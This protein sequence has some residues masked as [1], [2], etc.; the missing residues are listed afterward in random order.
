[1]QTSSDKVHKENKIQQRTGVE[2]VVLY[3]LRELM[4]RVE[5]VECLGN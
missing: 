2:L 5:V 4:S 1:M 3:I